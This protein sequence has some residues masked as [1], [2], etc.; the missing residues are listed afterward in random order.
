MKPFKNLKILSL[1][2]GF[3][4]IAITA[5]YFPIHSDI[6][7][8]TEADITASEPEPTNP[9]LEA[10]KTKQAIY[11]AQV[12][13]FS[14]KDYELPETSLSSSVGEGKCIGGLGGKMQVIH[15]GM[16]SE[17]LYNLDAEKLPT[18]IEG[19]YTYIPYVNAFTVRGDTLF[20]KPL[21]FF[22]RKMLTT[23]QLNRNISDSR[24]IINTVSVKNSFQNME[25]RFGFPVAYLEQQAGNTNTLSIFNDPCIKSFGRSQFTYKKI[26]L[27]GRKLTDMLSMVY[28]TKT[29]QT[30]NGLS[31]FIENSTDYVGQNFAEWMKGNNNIYLSMLSDK[32][33][34]FPKGS[35]FYIPEKFT[36]NDEVIYVNFDKNLTPYKNKE[37]WAK[38]NLETGRSLNDLEFVSEPFKEFIVYKLLDKTTHEP[39]STN[40]LIEKQHKFY[41]GNWQLPNTYQ[42]NQETQNRNEMVYF[43]LTAIESMLNYFKKK[44]QG[45]QLDI[46]T[47]NERLE[48]RRYETNTR[49]QELQE[50]YFNPEGLETAKKLEPSS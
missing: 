10:Y 6:N 31:S 34:V 14:R 36:V 37:E 1:I 21:D 20:K 38:A 41:I 9:E 4:G 16:F 27:S 42:V 35:F 8:N 23:Q 11:E 19:K 43:N 24:V 26:D 29:Y 45:S 40:V 46:G 47:E 25:T 22:N 30:I 33:A 5:L 50:K 48:E 32:N 39:V 12:T 13:S 7:K 28:T 3:T 49:L 17:P 15:S 2:V 18:D 44:T